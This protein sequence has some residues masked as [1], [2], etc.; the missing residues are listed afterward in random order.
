MTATTLVTL[1]RWA[2]VPLALVWLALV[3]ECV[4]YARVRRPR[5]P[6]DWERDCPELR[7]AYPRRHVHI[8]STLRR[9]Q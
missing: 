2:V 4:R 1:A 9:W 3:A 6:F 7:D 5:R 8:V